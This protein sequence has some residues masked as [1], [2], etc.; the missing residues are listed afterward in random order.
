MLK[1]RSP[2]LTQML[3]GDFKE[4]K[5]NQLM[6]PAF[7]DESVE[8]FIKFLYGYELDYNEVNIE[9]AQELGKL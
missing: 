7:S 4:K 1:N 8:I 2:V 9:I 3:T 6:F 5:E